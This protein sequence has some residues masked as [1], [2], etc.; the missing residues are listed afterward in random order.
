L[1]EVAQVSGKTTL[2]WRIGRGPA[3]DVAG[4]EPNMGPTDTQNLSLMAMIEVVISWLQGK[5]LPLGYGAALCVYHG[6]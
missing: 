1:V 3:A 5:G 4:N 6:D 2:N